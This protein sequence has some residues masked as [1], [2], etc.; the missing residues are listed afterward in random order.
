MPN[1]NP[2]EVQ[3]QSNQAEAI[4]KDLTSVREALRTSANTAATQPAPENIQ[5]QA[6][7]AS[8]ETA[9]KTG[10][11][12]NNPQMRTVIDA[13]RRLDDGNR[14]MDALAQMMQ[15][16]P[17][18]QSDALTGPNVPGIVPSTNDI[19]DSVTVGAARQQQVVKTLNDCVANI[20]DITKQLTPEHTAEYLAVRESL[21]ILRQQVNKENQNA[22]TKAVAEL[23]RLSQ[24]PVNNPRHAREWTR[25][26]PLI[27]QSFNV[28]GDGAAIMAEFSRQDLLFSQR[29]AQLR[30]LARE[31]GLEQREV[32]P[33]R[34]P[35]QNT[36]LITDRIGNRVNS[37][38]VQLFH[39]PAL[40]RFFPDMAAAQAGAEFLT[41]LFR[42][43][44]ADFLAFHEPNSKL[45]ANFR[46]YGLALH[47]ESAVRAEFKRRVEAN[48]LTF[49]PNAVPPTVRPT[50]TQGMIDALSLPSGTLVRLQDLIGKW[51]DGM[52]QRK[53]M[54]NMPTIMDD[55]FSEE[56][57]KIRMAQLDAALAAAPPQSTDTLRKSM[58]DYFTGN[59]PRS[60][61]QGESAMPQ[62]QVRLNPATALRFYKVEGPNRFCMKVNNDARVVYFEAAPDVNVTSM[63]IVND[64]NNTD[65]TNARVK[66]NGAV[67]GMRISHI[68]A[69]IV[70]ANV[71][72]T[73]IRFTPQA[74]DVSG[75]TTHE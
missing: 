12:A 39:S 55:A 32:Y 22:F 27:L 68:L 31:E 64:A 75:I 60:I 50:T 4:N 19:P 5:L 56:K 30:A 33:E 44:A 40:R 6:V 7:R 43:A 23:F 67:T 48:E 20:E 38:L 62:L 25:L 37:T 18:Q 61:N 35:D 45:W 13:L 57:K 15:G 63:D 24:D 54:G 46:R 21:R 73:K 26:Q 8:I 59:N 41:D 65:P 53:S 74:T 51:S 16:R 1:P 70:D 9:C 11:L 72:H 2:N 69:K 17:G 28:Q 52:R 29:H 66:I 42:S 34:L 71:A 58:T 36:S 10:L 3:R 49:S 47:V 14:K